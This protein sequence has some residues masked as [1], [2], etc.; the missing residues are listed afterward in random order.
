[1][2]IMLWLTLPLLLFGCVK[3]PKGIEPVAGFEAERYLG[4]WYEIARLDHFFE[5]GLEQVSAAYSFRQDGGIKVVNRG[6]D[7]K[8][9]EW[10]EV[11]GKA[12]FAEDPGTGRLKV[13]FWG[14]F[15]SAYN[16]IDLDK[17]N[18][19]WSLV[20]GP[21]RSYLWI[22]SRTPRMEESLKARL[23]KEAQKL[24]FETSE[25]IYVKH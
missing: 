8:K 25:L 2:K 5:R 7:P 16:I 6:Y 11:V 14:P 22:L 9:G 3:I 15:Y 20:C 21:N 4:T 23:V 24:G 17:E 1:M 18:Y 19:D 12:Y 13:S 10:K